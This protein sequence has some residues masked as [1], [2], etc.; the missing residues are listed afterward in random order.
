MK[1]LRN[2]NQGLVDIHVIYLGFP[3]WQERLK[4]LGSFICK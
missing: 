1:S 3:Y 2:L 4:K